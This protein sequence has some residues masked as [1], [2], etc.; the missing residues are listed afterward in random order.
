MTDEKYRFPFIVLDAVFLSE[1]GL[2]EEEKIEREVSKLDRKIMNTSLKTDDDEDSI[3]TLIKKSLHNTDDSEDYVS[4]LYEKMHDLY[5]NENCIKITRTGF[6]PIG[7]KSFN[8]VHGNLTLLTYFG[9]NFII[10]CTIDEFI[11]KL[12]NYYENTIT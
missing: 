1:Q 5:N 2:I 10:N 9:E 6:R 12:Q 7:I 8:E 4:T 3:E 11:T